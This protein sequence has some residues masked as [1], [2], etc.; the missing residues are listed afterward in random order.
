[1]SWDSYIDNLIAQTKDSS[2]AAHADKACII[3]IDGGAAWTT[4]AAGAAFQISPQEGATVASCFKSKDFTPFQASGIVLGGVKYQFLRS[5]DGKLVLGK[6]KDHGGVTLQCSKT[7]I[8][9]AHVAEG[10]QQGN[11]NKGV[12]VIA[13]YL[14]SLG[15]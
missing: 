12:G 8:V 13:E 15:M 10:S 9:I 14:E 5:E 3:G 1:M 11:V 7:A 6:K 4:N 2:G